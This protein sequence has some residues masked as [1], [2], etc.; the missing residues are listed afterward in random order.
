MTIQRDKDR[1][2]FPQ[3][4]SQHLLESL[5]AQVQQIVV[6]TLAE[7]T[8]YATLT[9]TQGKQTR[10]VDVRLSD[11]L[12]LAVRTGAPIYATH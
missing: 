3:D 11:A 9:L 5:D 7:Q 10:E 6:N 8:F 4:L 12:A 1:H 2:P